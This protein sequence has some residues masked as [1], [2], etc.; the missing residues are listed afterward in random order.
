MDGRDSQLYSTTL[1]NNTG[2]CLKVKAKLSSGICYGT[3][4]AGACGWQGIE[5]FFVE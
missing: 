3:A 2:D 5:L 4:P 1:F